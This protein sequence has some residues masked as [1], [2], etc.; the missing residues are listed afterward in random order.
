M[1]QIIPQKQV[2]KSGD[3]KIKISVLMHFQTGEL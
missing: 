2:T 3:K 1:D